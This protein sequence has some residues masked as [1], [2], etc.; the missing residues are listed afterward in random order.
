MAE[1]C[2]THGTTCLK[3]CSQKKIGEETFRKT[4]THRH[5]HTYIHTHIYIYIYIYIYINKIQNE[6][7]KGSESMNWI[8]LAQA[9]SSNLLM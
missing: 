7:L 3:S 1:T 4:H 9:K 8:H 5:I 6:S 2:S